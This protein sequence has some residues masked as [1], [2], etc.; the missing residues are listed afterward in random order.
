MTRTILIAAALAAALSGAA[1]ASDD[2]PLDPAKAEQIRASLTAQGYEVRSVQTEDGLY[3]V[4]AIKDGKKMEVYLND[5]LEIV[6]TDED[7]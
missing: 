7:S 5:A 2:K 4:Y 6:R 3:E 1:Q